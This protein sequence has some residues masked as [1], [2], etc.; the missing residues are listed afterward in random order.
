MRHQTYFISGRHVA[1][2]RAMA[3][4]KQT[5]LAQLAGLHVNSLKRLEAMK[6]VLVSVHAANR[7]G[8]ALKL[9]G[10]IAE[11]WPP[12]LIRLADRTLKVRVA[13]TQLID[14]D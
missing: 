1:A 10:V 4:L 14:T 5:E 8:E 7:A 12:P 11:T 9:K 3:G 13:Q 6:S 2:S